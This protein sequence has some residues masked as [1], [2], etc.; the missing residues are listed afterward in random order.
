MENIEL[1]DKYIKG[2]LS[3][4]ECK[5][6]DIRLNSDKEFAA[7]FRV[8]SATV[9]GI[10]KEAQQDNIDF[11]VAMKKLTKEQ[12]REIIAPRNESNQQLKVAK[13]KV[14]RLKP[15]IWQTASIA[16]VV[17]IAFTVVFNMQ[18]QS[19]Y[20]VDY[21][22]YACADINTDLTRAGGEPIN[23]TTMTEEELRAK[24]IEINSLFQSST[25]NDEIADNG[26][27]L[28]MAYLRLHKR[29]K[30][31]EILNQLVSRFNKNEDYADSVKKWKSILNLIK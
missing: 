7:D 3:E 27:A 31:S 22:I 16:A 17:V 2:E 30:A 6:F 5:E 10:C 13:P 24:L 29:D 14:V 25:T 28:A 12:L 23:I 8:Y 4:K 15:W 1:F 20:A 9:I 18:K 26:Y 21:A 19:Q 11:G